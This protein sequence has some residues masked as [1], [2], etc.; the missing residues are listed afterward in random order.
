MEASLP[1]FAWPN[2]VLG[3]HDQWRM[4]T[5]FGGLAQARGAGM[6]L[7]TLRGTPTFYYGDEIGL[8]NG[9]IPPEKIQDPQ[10]KNLGAERTRDVCRTP[11]Q[12]DASPYA[13]FSTVEPW[14]PVTADYKTRNVAVEAQDPASMLSFFRRLFWL[15]NDSPALSTGSYQALDPAYLQA[16]EENC[17]V[18]QRESG[19]ERKLVVLNFSS[20]PAVIDTHLEGKGQTLLSTHMDRSGEVD[21]RKVEL[22]PNEGLVID[23]PSLARPLHSYS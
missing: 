19:P 1:P 20:Q 6:M 8:E 22:R 10:G 14:L 7:L 11:M 3:N 16:G 5:R 13:G 4:A 15:R 23:R 21:L 2:Y 18:Y 9:V 17:Y 12:W